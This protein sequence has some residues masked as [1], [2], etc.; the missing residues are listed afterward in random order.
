MTTPNQPGSPTTVQTWPQSV[1]TGYPS[2]SA[3]TLL[4][5]DSSGSGNIIATAALPVGAIVM[6]FSAT[7][8]TGWQL[9]DGTNGSP[10]LQGRF[11][12]GVGANSPNNATFSLGNQGGEEQ[13][14]LTTDEMPSHSHQVPLSDSNSAQTAN[15]YGG[16]S[17]GLSSSAPT[18][19]TGGSQAHNIMPPFTVVNFIMKIA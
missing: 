17:N 3:T 12:L 2:G 19:N 9:C 7:I 1:I 13:H 14:T 11:P 18:A 10:D 8:P 16:V 6:W 5:M 15:Y 4:G